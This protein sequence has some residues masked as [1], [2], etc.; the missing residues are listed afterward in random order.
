MWLQNNSTKLV[1]HGQIL[2]TVADWPW[3]HRPWFKLITRVSQCRCVDRQVSKWTLWH[4]SLYTRP[5]ANIYTLFFSV[6]PLDGKWCILERV[7]C[8]NLF[9]IHS[10]G[11]LLRKQ[12]ISKLKQQ[13]K[14]ISYWGEFEKSKSDSSYTKEHWLL[15]LS[16][17]VTYHQL[18]Y[19]LAQEDCNKLSDFLLSWNDGMEIVLRIFGQELGEKS[20]I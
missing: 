8:I 7:F 20:S 3:Q 6:D 14:K 4:L 10:L 19:Y 16:C 18:D 5:M 12:D 2:G 9:F 17:S 1:L 11:S 15:K 13:Q